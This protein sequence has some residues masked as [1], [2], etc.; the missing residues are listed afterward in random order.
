VLL[1]YFGASAFVFYRQHFV[2]PVVAPALALIFAHG[3]ASA[4]RY[5][6]TGRE[7]RQTRRVLERYV[8]PQLVD[9]IMS[10]L[11]A[12]Q[13]S[14]TKRELTIL[15]SDVRNFT[16]MTEKADPEEL[17]HL[18]N[19]YLEAMTEIIFKH[20]G[21]VD[22]FIGD[23]ILAYWGAFTPDKNHAEQASLAALEMIEQ[24]KI[25]NGRWQKEGKEPISIGIG[26]NTGKVVFGNIGKG[27]KIEF[28]VIGDAVNFAAKL[29][30]HNKDEKTRALVDAN[31][32][33]L[34]ERQGYVPPAV[35]ERRTGRPVGG[36]AEP[37]DVVVLAK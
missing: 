31:T 17:I 16:T 27:K 1:L 32:Y 35:R 23:G 25:L 19:D 15:I 5:A 34:A 10:N 18:L 26:I 33:A 2:L 36:V 24:L 22:K 28:T 13:L 30:K 20:N 3:S 11:S 37:I 14:G 4:A 12:L 7:L 6:T 29:E 8:A 9:Y 21:I